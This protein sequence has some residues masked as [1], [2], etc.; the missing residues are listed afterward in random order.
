MR[1]D[2]AGLAPDDR[3]TVLSIDP[4][5][6]TRA[7]ARAIYRRELRRARRPGRRLRPGVGAMSARALTFSYLALW[8]ATLTGAALAAAGARLQVVDAP[9]PALDAEPGHRRRAGRAQR[10]GRA[11][12]AR[13]RRAGLARAARRAHR[14]RPARSRRSCSPTACSSAPPSASTPSCGATCPTCHWSGSRSRIPA[15]AWLTARTRPARP[16]RRRVAL[17]AG[18]ALVAL[19]GAAAI[20]TYLTPL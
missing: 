18:A 4:G 10:P 17:V 7:H 12:A 14:R 15:A 9:R 5:R 2:I 19:A 6:G 16:S 20:E 8:L 13:A 1:I 3:T 11:V